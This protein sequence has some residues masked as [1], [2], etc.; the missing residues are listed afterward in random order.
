[1]VVVALLGSLVGGTVVLGAQVPD[2]EGSFAFIDEAAG[3]PIRWDPCEPVHYQVNLENAPADALDLVREAFDRTSRVTGIEFA[4]DGTTTRTI[5]EQERD[6]YLSHLTPPVVWLP[7]LVVWLP[8][9]E[10]RQRFERPGT[11][12]HA[13]AVA[14]PIRGELETA[15]QYTSGSI[16]VDAGAHLSEDFDGRYSLGMVLMHEAGHLMGLGH[17]TDPAEVM[18]S[19]PSRYPYPVEDWGP[20]DVEGLE[21]LGQGGCMDRV[22]VSP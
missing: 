3:A 6:Y 5:R 11:E 13:L 1:L 2:R 21:I 15:D 9:D 14:R 20:G 16:A 17:V 7:V 8:R 12:R 22:P 10:F 18:F 4:F 19:D